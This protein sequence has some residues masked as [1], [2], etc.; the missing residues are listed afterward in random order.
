MD[1]GCWYGSWAKGADMESPLRTGGGH[2]CGWLECDCGVK[3]DLQRSD[4]ADVY[5]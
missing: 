2:K 5:D 1:A 3:V 4:R